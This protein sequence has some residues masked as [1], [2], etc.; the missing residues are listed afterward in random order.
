MMHYIL[1]LI[2]TF[3]G[4]FCSF[5]ISRDYTAVSSPE[6]SDVKRYTPVHSDAVTSVTVAGDV[7]YITGSADQV[8]N[9]VTA[10]RFSMSWSLLWDFVKLP[11]A[12]TAIAM[13]PCKS[14]VVPFANFHTH[15]HFPH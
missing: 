3:V 11:T 13:V 1:H 15:L 12:P 9:V 5:D 14:A 6:V 4:I 10:L 2:D 7:S 8:I